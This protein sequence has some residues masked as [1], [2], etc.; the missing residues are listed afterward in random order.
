LTNKV[1]TEIKTLSNNQVS[2]MIAQ[3]SK[4]VPQSA[5]SISN[6]LGLGK[7]GL[8]TEQLEKGGYLKPGVVNNFVGSAG[9]TTT[10]ILNNSA[11]W[12]GKDGVK[13]VQKLLNNET[14]QNNV[15]V[16]LWKNEYDD[17]LVKGA[18]S[19]NE[20]PAKLG[21]MLTA[22]SKFGT[23]TTLDWV[24][25]KL[26][27]NVKSE[28]DKI[29]K[30]SQMAINLVDQK[31]PVQA[32]NSLVPPLAKNTTNRAAVDQA[33]SA[34]IGNSKI[35]TPKFAPPSIE[36]V[37]STDDGF[38]ALVNTATT[39][40]GS[41]QDNVT[42][43]ES[44]VVTVTNPPADVVSIPSSASKTISSSGGAVNRK[45]DAAQACGCSENELIAIGSGFAGPIWA[46]PNGKVPPGGPMQS[47]WG[48]LIP[49]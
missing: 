44:S 11:V 30:S 1:T 27:G 35:A 32:K 21:G 2:G 8:S 29:A 43:Y 46:C 20:D 22:A 31:V 39:P 5:T 41:N 17:L 42:G 37:L 12:T 6:D 45:R 9:K 15:Q 7:F 26:P 33:L 49:H 24:K 48:T 38:S 40:R 16:N 25:G 14:L 13:D 34:L 4:D 23:E 18:I 19:G 36:S 28:F 47:N 3:V 10:E